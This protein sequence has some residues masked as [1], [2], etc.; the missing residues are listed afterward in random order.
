[1]RSE[2]ASYWAVRLGYNN[3]KRFPYGYLGWKEASC[4]EEAEPEEVRKLGVADY[5]PSCR[6]ILLDY[7]KD[8]KYL[9]IEHGKRC[10][11]LKDVNSDYI[12]IELYNELCS[13]CLQEV[14]NYKNFYRL[15]NANNLLKDKVV[16]IGIGVGSKRRNVAKFRKEKNILFPLFADEHGEIFKCLGNPTMPTAYLVQKQ[17]NGARKIVLVQ[18]GHIGSVDKLMK[19]IMSAVTGGKD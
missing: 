3:I 6:L 16:M 15:L 4:P 5:F 12:F 10:F 9:Q 8:R 19:K 1:M 14:K 13:G 18:P 2:I 7:A 11:S 17:P